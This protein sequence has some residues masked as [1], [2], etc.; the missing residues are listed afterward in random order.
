MKKLILKWLGLQTV[1]TDIKT[2]EDSTYK[3]VEELVNDEFH[4]QKW[5]FI[6]DTRDEL[7]AEIDIE[8][9]VE[10]AIADSTEISSMND[11]VQA[12]EDKLTEL[13]AGYKL[14]VQLIKE[15]F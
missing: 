3:V 15:D 1:V 12:L 9:Q 4:N 8:R 6:S 5:D 10:D 14:E 2:L 7:E 13:V 11:K